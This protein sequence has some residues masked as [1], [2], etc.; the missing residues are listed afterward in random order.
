MMKKLL[1]ALTLLIPTAH[2]E[3]AYFETSSL[4]HP[5][6]SFVLQLTDPK[7]IDKARELLASGGHTSHHFAGYVVPGKTF[8]NPE[9]SFHVDTDSIEF[10][11]FSIEVCDAH[12]Q[13]VE[14]HFEEVGG[15]FLPENIWCPWT[16]RLVR[17]IEISTIHAP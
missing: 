17:E 11:E 13:F 4:V 9:W 8:Y 7:K 3:V 5:D 10:A 16:S 12:P 2:A 6:K 15:A 1:F 14:D